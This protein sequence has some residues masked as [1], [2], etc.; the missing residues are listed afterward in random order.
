MPL[1]EK[2]VKVRSTLTPAAWAAATTSVAGQPFLAP[3]VPA[4]V[5][6]MLNQA[7]CVNASQR[8]VVRLS[9]QVGK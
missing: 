4:D 7:M 9:D 5:I 3:R 8:I 6:T 1:P 2:S